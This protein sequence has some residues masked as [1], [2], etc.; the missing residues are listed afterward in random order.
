MFFLR[1][2]RF[3]NKQFSAE[4]RFSDRKKIRLSHRMQIDS[5]SDKHISAEISLERK[6]MLMTE[7]P[8]NI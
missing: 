5:L 2:S 7:I 3:T 1:C 8:H 6:Q 4:M